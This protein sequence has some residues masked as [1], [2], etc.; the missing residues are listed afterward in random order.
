[1]RFMMLMIPGGY[2]TAAPDAM[3]SAES[4]GVRKKFKHAEPA[5][6][7]TGALFPRWNLVPPNAFQERGVP[8]SLEPAVIG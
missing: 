5:I 4:T 2:A 6:P 1:M 8:K 3:P 7:T